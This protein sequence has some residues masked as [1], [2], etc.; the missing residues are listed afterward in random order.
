MDMADKAGNIGY[1]LEGEDLVRFVQYEKARS[2]QQE[3]LLGVKRGRSAIEMA[4]SY[5]LVPEDVEMVLY[6]LQVRST[7]RV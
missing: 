2:M 3:L 6:A 4:E 5:G 7:A 1:D